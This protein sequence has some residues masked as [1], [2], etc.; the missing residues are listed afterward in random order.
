MNCKRANGVEQMGIAT[1]FTWF[2]KAAKG[3]PPVGGSLCA[4]TPPGFS[5]AAFRCSLYAV[6]WILLDTS[7]R[8]GLPDSEEKEKRGAFPQ[9]SSA[10]GRSEKPYAEN[11]EPQPH[12]PVALG[13]SNVKPDPIIFVT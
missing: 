11:D 9:E 5:A 12:P 6:L 8:G 3:E 4:P 10:A 2:R 1:H 13:F 7:N